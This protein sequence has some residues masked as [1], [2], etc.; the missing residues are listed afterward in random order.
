MQLAQFI[1]E[2]FSLDEIGFAPK[3]AKKPILTSILAITIIVAAGGIRLTSEH[4]IH[5]CEVL[6]HAD[7]NARLH[8]IFI[9]KSAA[10]AQA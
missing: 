1:V 2:Y 6:R 8:L 4:T 7:L 5:Q 3:L 10:T 9:L